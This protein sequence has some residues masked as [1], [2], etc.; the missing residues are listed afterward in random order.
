MCEFKLVHIGNSVLKMQAK[1]LCNS[2]SR[3]IVSF[4]YGI[5]QTVKKQEDVM[6]H[7]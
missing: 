5:I 2:L 4:Q 1:L 7:T 6:S 3:L